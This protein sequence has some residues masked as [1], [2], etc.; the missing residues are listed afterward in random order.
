MKGGNEKVL[1]LDVADRSTSKFVHV[2]Q[3]RIENQTNKYLT[4][5][6]LSHYFLIST[7][8]GLL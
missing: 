8:Y 5:C 3:D 7:Y 1:T 4:I 6:N 2:K